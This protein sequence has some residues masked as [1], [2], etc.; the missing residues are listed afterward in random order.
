[1]INK[2]PRTAKK[3]YRSQFGLIFVNNRSYLKPLYV[4]EF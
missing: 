4:D 3:Q 1:M 2:W